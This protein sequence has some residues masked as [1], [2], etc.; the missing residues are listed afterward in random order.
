MFYFYSIV[1]KTLSD[2]L[3]QKLCNNV[4]MLYVL[5]I[6]SIFNSHF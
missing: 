4:I 2:D 3:R 1:I 6:K 5:I